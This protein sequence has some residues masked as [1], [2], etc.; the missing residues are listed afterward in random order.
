VPLPDTHGPAILKASNLVAVTTSVGS[1]LDAL[2]NLIALDD[3]LAQI[4][5]TRALVN[6][7]ADLDAPQPSSAHLMEDQGNDGEYIES[8][9]ERVVG[10]VAVTSHGA[11]MAAGRQPMLAS[12]GRFEV[13]SRDRLNLQLAKLPQRFHDMV[14]AAFGGPTLLELTASHLASRLLENNTAASEL[15]AQGYPQHIVNMVKRLMATRGA[16]AK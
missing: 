9:D 7:E 10:Q 8:V 4:D 3:E 6:E 1:T 11:E 16:S 15:R 5:R 13:T 2:S 14:A 12:R